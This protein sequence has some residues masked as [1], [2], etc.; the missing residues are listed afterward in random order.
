[1]YAIQEFNASESIAGLTSSIYVIGAM[2]TR[3]LSGK[4][5][6]RIGRKKTLLAG[7]LIFLLA[8]LL[9]FSVENL[10]LLMGVRFIHG[11]A[12]GV[13]ATAMVTAAMDIIP[14]ER[15]G[16]GTNYYTMSP[17]LAVAIGPFLGVFISQHASIKMVFLVST[18]L[19]VINIIISLFAHLPVATV[20][21][22]QLDA[23]KGFKWKDFFEV[24]ALPIAFFAAIATLGYSG[25]IAFIN[26]YAQEINLI[27]EASYFFIIYAVV[28][29]ISRPYT[30]RL[31]DRKGENIV[32][33]PSMVLLL[34]GL[35]LLSQAHQGLSLLVAG[36]LCGLGYGNIYSSAQAIAIKESPKH[37]VA[38]ATSTYYVMTDLGLGIGPFIL[39]TIVPLAGFRSLYVTE[40]AIIFAC[41]FLYYIIHGKKTLYSKERSCAG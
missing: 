41:L 12:F 32:L 11:A 3:L 7:S 29:L 15:R 17:T 27:D 13:A 24:N 19:A 31:F 37:R 34:L 38:L 6:E 30:G 36:A 23:M 39:G 18:V 4:Y 8:T 1:M 28:L 33:Y 2:I 16:E 10:I 14:N 26:P 25:I 20:T 35:L 9:Y 5:I 21:K 22:E 40:A